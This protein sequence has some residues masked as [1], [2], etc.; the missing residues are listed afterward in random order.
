M[1]GGDISGDEEEVVEQRAFQAELEREA[2]KGLAEDEVI[3]VS[4]GHSRLFEQRHTVVEARV[5]APVEDG[6]SLLKRLRDL[7]T[8]RLLSGER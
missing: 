1:L 3:E 7:C 2:E 4:L 8:R 6:S 5:N